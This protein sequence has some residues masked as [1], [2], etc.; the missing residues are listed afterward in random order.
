[1]DCVDLLF[2]F[3][4]WWFDFGARFGLNAVVVCVCCGFDWLLFVGVAFGFG[5]V[6]F[7]RGGL[8]CLQVLCLR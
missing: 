6:T 7:V 5:C 3:A 4:G 1:M 2:L 8:V